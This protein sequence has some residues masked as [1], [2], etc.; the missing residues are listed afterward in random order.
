MLGIH[1]VCTLTVVAGAKHTIETIK[2]EPTLSLSLPPPPPRRP[3]RLTG[4]M[5]P[6]ILA[7]WIVGSILDNPRSNRPERMTV[8]VARELTRY[9]VGIAAST[10]T[11]FSEEGRLEDVGADYTFF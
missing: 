1:A 5:S 6:L 10:E 11:R 8:L 4:R 2:I 7:A 9:N 3:T